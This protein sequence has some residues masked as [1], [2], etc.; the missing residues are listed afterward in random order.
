MTRRQQWSG[1]Y[2]MSGF[3][4]SVFGTH[5]ASS[6]NINSSSSRRACATLAS[7]WRTRTAASDI[8]A[9]I[10]QRNGQ[11]CIVMSFR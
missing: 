8:P 7:T 6:T 4:T 2:V 9:A 3:R 5:R 10:P 11:L 1:T